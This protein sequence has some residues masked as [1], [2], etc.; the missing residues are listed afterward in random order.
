MEKEGR[1]GTW[2]NR[3]VKCPNFSRVSSKST[4][5]DSRIFRSNQYARSV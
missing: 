4:K 2:Q 5:S 3:L 1:G